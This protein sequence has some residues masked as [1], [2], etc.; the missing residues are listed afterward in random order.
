MHDIWLE[1]PLI[2]RSWMC[3]WIWANTVT[4]NLQDS[5]IHVK[6]AGNQNILGIEK[7]PWENEWDRG[8]IREKRER[9]KNLV[10]QLSTT[11]KTC[12]LTSD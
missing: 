4:I 2:R 9:K 12:T 11:S 3:A 8:W 7:Q 1:I 10:H 6:I 5:Y